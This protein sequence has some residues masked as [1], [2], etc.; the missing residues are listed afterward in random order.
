MNTLKNSYFYHIITRIITW[1]SQQW[2]DS[3]IVGWFTNQPNEKRESALNRAGGKLRGLWTGIFQKLHL[4]KLL[5]GSIFLHPMLFTGAAV[6]LAPLV[7][8]MAVLA[9]VCCGF[10][11]LFVT[12]GV[13]HETHITPSP[14]SAY[15]LLYGIIYLYAIVTSTN[16]KGS[17]YP[18]LLT[19]LFIMGFFLILFCNPEGKKLEGLLWCLMVVGVIVSFYGFYQVVFPE[20]FRNVWTDEDMFSNIAFRVY[21]TLENPNVLGEYFLLIIPLGVAMLFA[22][23]NWFKRILAL[24]ACGIM[25]SCLILTYSRGCYLGIL[26]AAVVFLALLDRRFIVLGIIAVALCPLYLPE[27]VLTRFASIGDMGDS[28]TSYRVYIWLGTLA[29][30][31]DYWFCGVGPGIDAYNMVYPEYA[32]NAVTAPHSHSLY[33]QL[34]CDSGI[35]GLGVFLILMV[36]FF[37]MMF[38]AIRKETDRK[39]RI[40]QVGGV[41]AVTGFMVQ[42]ATD[43]TFYNYRVLFLFWAVLAL[44]VLFAQMGCGKESVTSKK[45]DNL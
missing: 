23:D 30:L 39:A 19:V 6:I 40:F 35:C 2:L 44:C 45:G 14:I 7:P 20:K 8:T 15:V 43:F 10:V 33:L 11:S 3:R 29:M 16:F 5:Q 41:S 38:T 26:F 22:S 42:G 28:S 37:R 36:A 1:F 21:A 31:K 32:Y 18:G 4:N 27:S 17:L 12:L 24:V 13:D 34:M 25:G 9:L